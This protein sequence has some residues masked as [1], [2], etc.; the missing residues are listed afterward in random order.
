MYSFSL[1]ERR[2]GYVNGCMVGFFFLLA[3]A[4]DV[5]VTVE[6]R[7]WGSREPI[8]R[9]LVK[10][11][12]AAGEREALTDFHGRALFRVERPGS[13][14][15]E[16]KAEGFFSI[17]GRQEILLP[18]ESKG[19]TMR[20]YL[21]RA[22]RLTGVLLDPETEKPIPKLRVRL[23]R[24]TKF[25]GER[26]LA[27]VDTVNA[28]G[29]D[30]AFSLTGYTPGEFILKI[31]Q[32]ADAVTIR[33][34]TGELDAAFEK[35]PQ[36]TGIGWSYWPGPKPEEPDQGVKVEFGWQQ[37]IGKVFVPKVP[38]FA[39]A[40]S[41]E[42][43]F[44]LPGERADVAAY[45]RKQ[46]VSERL[47]KLNV[48]CGSGYVVENLP[49][50][51][52]VFE[53]LREG[54]ES[55]SMKVRVARN[56]RVRLIGKPGYRLIPRI[57]GLERRA[58]PPKLVVGL[59]YSDGVRAEWNPGSTYW[60]R[61]DE[62]YVFE[63]SDLP[64]NYYHSLNAFSEQ[65]FKAGE[66]VRLSGVRFPRFE[67]VVA[68]PTAVIEGS[69]VDDKDQATS[70]MVEAVREDQPQWKRRAMA[71]DDGKF[72]LKGLPPGKYKLYAVDAEEKGVKVDAKGGETQKVELRSGK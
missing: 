9:A 4:T 45:R 44:C 21:S 67:S 43:R 17:E 52:Y 48:K 69:V 3:A 41:V 59:A 64:E 15:V 10:V 55:S 16:A 29:V 7:E 56:E 49:Y 26:M 27:P 38:L 33:E 46:Y 65:K 1:H 68:K 20:V 5:A 30:G 51:E 47:A 14:S 71:G 25:R 19:M 66:V 28:T 42:G 11:M 22:A 37:E 23:L 6:V 35:L 24:E 31:D 34:E 58:L 2:R 53:A 61:A 32:P 13:Y 36:R 70:R 60:M 8:D 72:T 50:G 57:A 18:V 54:V 40:V 63:L 39:V 12:S 62:P